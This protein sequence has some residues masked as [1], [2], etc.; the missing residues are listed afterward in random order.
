M[1]QDDVPKLF[2]KLMDAE[3][4]KLQNWGGICMNSFRME[5]GIRLFSKDFT[6]DHSALEAG[7]KK[8]NI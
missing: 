8:L 3:G 4:S 6:K 5:K 7:W 2:K 1:A